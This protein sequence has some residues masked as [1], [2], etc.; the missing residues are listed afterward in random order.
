MCVFVTRVM[1]VTELTAD[2]RTMN[3][4]KRTKSDPVL[5]DTNTRCSLLVESPDSDSQCQTTCNGTDAHSAPVN[6][7]NCSTS[8]KKCD[9]NSQYVALDCEFVG[10]GPRQLSALGK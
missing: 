9:D 6:A 3:D 5:S 7:E 8:S 4:S 2:N 10:V 1:K